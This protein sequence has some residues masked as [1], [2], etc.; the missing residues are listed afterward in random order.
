MRSSAVID[1]QKYPLSEYSRNNMICRYTQGSV[2]TQTTQKKITANL[3]WQDV[4]LM[5]NGAAT[6][7]DS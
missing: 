2:D 6:G 4:T 1:C 3:F 7:F 5:L